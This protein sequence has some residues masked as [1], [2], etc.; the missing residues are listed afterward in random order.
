M[1]MEVLPWPEAKDALFDKLEE[2]ITRE[3][4]KIQHHKGDATV[5][6]AEAAAEPSA[7]SAE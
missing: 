6:N 7:P 4:A 1:R 5:R 3:K 2:K